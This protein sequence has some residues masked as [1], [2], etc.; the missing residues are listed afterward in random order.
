MFASLTI[1]R[2]HIVKLCSLWTEATGR[3]FP[4]S[5]VLVSPLVL[6]NGILPILHKNRRHCKIMFDSGG[7]H[8][9]QQILTMQD[10]SSRLASL[11]R[12][13]DWADIYVLPDS[14]LISTDNK[15]QISHKLR[16]TAR[17]YTHFA[18][19]LPSRLFSKLLPVVHG[20]TLSQVRRSATACGLDSGSALG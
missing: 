10:T 9:Q 17:G 3:Q 5:N 7:F 13:H 4:F 1:N 2:C 12:T 16:A 8:V 19:Q 15:Q 11:Y 14:P 18:A 20:S 6:R